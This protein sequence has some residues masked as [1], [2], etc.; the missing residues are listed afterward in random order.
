VDPNKSLLA[1]AWYSCLLRGS[2]TAWQIQK[3]MHAAI[4]W[5]KHR[6]PNEGARESSQDAEGVCSPLGG[7]T[8]WT[9]QYPQSSLWLNHQPKKIHGGTHGFSCIC[10]RE[11]PSRSSMGGETHTVLITV[12]GHLMPFSGL[13]RNCMHVVHTNVG[14][15]LIYIN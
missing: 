13:H 15:S 12:P 5:T 6:V 3:W 10:S 2:A 4:Y 14:K 8:I 11:W 7:T 9:H 1:G